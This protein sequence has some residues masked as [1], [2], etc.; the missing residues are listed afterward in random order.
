MTS[1]IDQYR[2]GSEPY[3]EAQGNEIALY[4]AAYA[5]RSIFDFTVESASSR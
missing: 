4:E 1:D 2:I 5:A 3:Y